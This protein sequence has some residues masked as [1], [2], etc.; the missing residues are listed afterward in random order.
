MDI[1]TLALLRLGFLRLALECSLDGTAFV[2]SGVIITAVTAFLIKCFPSEFC[3]KMRRVTAAV[4]YTNCSKLAV[5]MCMAELLAV[6]ALN[7][8]NTLVR[9]D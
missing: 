2:I 5:R 3:A 9:F 6:Q 8:A 4:F 1:G 7:W